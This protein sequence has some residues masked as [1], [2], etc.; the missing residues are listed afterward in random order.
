NETGFQAAIESF[1]GRWQ[2]KVW[3]RFQY[4]QQRAVRNQSR[5]YIAAVRQRNAPR[6]EAAPTRNVMPDHWKL[7]LQTTPRGKIIFLRRTND[8]GQVAIL[9][10]PF[11][12]DQHWV[13][14]LVRAEIDLDN[15]RIQFYA[16]R[17]RDPFD[18]PL[19]SQHEYQFPNKQ[20]LE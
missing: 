13:H 18:Q 20:F 14:R 7:N 12:V 11:T 3:S 15:H 9:K 2:A 10:N 6:I 16:L 19:L 1:N 17:R 5:N 8:K 4:A